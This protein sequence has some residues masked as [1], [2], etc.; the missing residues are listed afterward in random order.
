V[1]LSHSNLEALC[2][3]LRLA[4]HSGAAGQTA[5][6]PGPEP[7]RKVR[8]KSVGAAGRGPLSRSV[9][10]MANSGHGN[11]LRTPFGQRDEE[12]ERV[13]VLTILSNLESIVVNLD[14]L[15]KKIGG[16]IPRPPR[17]PSHRKLPFKQPPPRARA[18]CTRTHM[19][20]L[21]VA[22]PEPNLGAPAPQSL[23]A[24]AEGGG[25]SGSGLAGNTLLLSAT[26]GTGSTRVSN[27]S[28]EE[29]HAAEAST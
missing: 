27:S 20:S 24:M 10:S 29:V 12:K 8:P 3:V 4:G 25:G 22:T 19:S 26:V 11:V 1:R 28:H 16:W 2:Q 18:R 9:G 21:P 15:N 6:I 13:N 7:V 23:L 5:S 17:P 14:G